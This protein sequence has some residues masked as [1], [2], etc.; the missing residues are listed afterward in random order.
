M[1]AGSAV[2]NTSTPGSDAMAS[3]SVAL[4]IRGN[5]IA[6]TRSVPA[7]PGNRGHFA[8]ASASSE[9]SH[10]WSSHGT[11]PKHRNP[12]RRVSS[13]S[14]GSSTD[15]SPRNLLMRYPASSAR[16]E[17]STIPQWPKIDA[18]TPPRSMSPTSSVGSPNRCARPKL[19]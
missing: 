16:S 19:T 6:A 3:K 17:S 8:K 14:P 15:W 9:S 5:R 7:R 1:S 13:S 10:T 18:N 2:A 4:E 12:V 11:T